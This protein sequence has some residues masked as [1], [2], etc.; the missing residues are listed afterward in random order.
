[1]CLGSA[2]GFMQGIWP[3]RLAEVISAV[4]ALRRWQHAVQKSW[5]THRAN[6]FSGRETDQT[7]WVVTLAPSI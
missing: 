4:V 2:Y 1:M 6:D 3:L 5:F 7:D